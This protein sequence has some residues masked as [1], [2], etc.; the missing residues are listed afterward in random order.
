MSQQGARRTPRRVVV[1]GVGMVTPLG[2][3]APATWEAMLAGRQ[4]FSPITAFDA[5]K[6]RNP[7][8]GVVPGYPEQALTDPAAQPR[9]VR[10]LIDAARE[11][12]AHAALG[13]THPG[14]P[15]DLLFGTNFG[16]MQA[17]E[18]ALRASDD[19]PPAQRS[20][21]RYN[22]AQ[23]GLQVQKALGVTGGLNV[24]S[25]ACSSGGSAI[26]EGFDRVRRGQAERLLVGGY[27]ELSQF[28]LAGLNALRAITPDTI[29]PWDKERQG[30]LFAEGAACLVL[31]E[32]TAAQQRGALILGEVLG[33][34]MNNDAYHMTAPEK[35]GRGIQACMAM[36]LA[37]AGLPPAAVDHFNAHGTGTPY[38]DAVETRSVLAIFGERGRTIPITANKSQLGHTMGAAGAI[39]AIV[40][41]LSMK[42]G[43]IPP[44]VGCREQ[45]SELPVTI[46]KDTP[47]EGEY[48]V[49]L[50]NSYG[51]GG[52]N[53]SLV[54]GQV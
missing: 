40:S 22:F 54:L 36:A 30:T 31:E 42:H 45:D 14:E 24:I 19:A 43:V 6:F 5:S 3:T 13:K 39:E 49:T 28:C 20:L 2:A 8:A 47:R 52:T 29:R 1:T 12:F 32:F 26:A 51:F 15:L 4:G 50:S 18:A 33:R 48:A 44:I 35:E 17:A 34:G 46:V 10:F 16:G 41:L 21:A 27:D 37:D 9:A 11:A 23:A 38:N 7:L 25:L 53:C